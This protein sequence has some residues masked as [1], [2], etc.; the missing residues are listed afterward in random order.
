MNDKDLLAM[1]VMGLPSVV[2]IALIAL[3]LVAV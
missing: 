1:L 2:L 3:V